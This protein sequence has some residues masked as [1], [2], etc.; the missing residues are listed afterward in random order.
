MVAKTDKNTTKKIL[1]DLIKNKIGQQQD[2]VFFFS[3]GDKLRAAVL[4]LQKGAS[5]DEI[6]EILDWRDFEGLIAEI[7]ESKDFGTIKNLILKNPK[8]EI[9]VVGIKLGIALLI[10]CKHWRKMTSSALQT[11][12]E[13]Q[14]QRTK[15]YVSQTQGSIAVPVI[16]T[17]YHDETN[18]ID[19][20]PIVPVTQFS[21]FIDEFYGNLSDMTTIKSD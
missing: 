17:L 5:I 3:S 4:A 6:S 15:Q 13:K 10:D 9:D 14:I 12:V 11:I 18:F 1:E 7:L 19:K 21:S 20:V 16:V 8:R 2:N